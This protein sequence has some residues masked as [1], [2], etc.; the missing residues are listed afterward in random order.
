M[1]M[2]NPRLAGRYAKSLIDL[3]I[4]K[5][6][7]EAVYRDMLF[8]Q[9]ACRGS[10]ELVKLLKSP[11]IKADKK[12]RILDA[13]TDGK[14]SV[15]TA[16]FNKLLL[17]KGRESFLPEIISAFI[18]QYKEYKGIHTVNLTTAI[19]VSEELKQSIMD[20]IRADSNLK[21]IELNTAVEENLIGGFILEIGDKLLDASIAFDL[22]NIKKQ[23]RNND[24]IYK[25]R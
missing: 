13:L 11:V 21:N 25:I 17:N 12:G 2:P 24:F 22:N 23:F 10:K 8:L 18:D 14:I 4:E 19:P 6:Q 15:I 9:A 1:S 7:L 5:D 16:T 3:S 20:K